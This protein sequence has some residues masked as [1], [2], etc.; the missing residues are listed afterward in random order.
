MTTWTARA[1]LLAAD[2]PEHGM[3]AAHLNAA[4]W[5]AGIMPEAT[6]GLIGAY[7]ALT[8]NRGGDALWVRT[9]PCPDAAALMLATAELEAG[10]AGL[11]KRAETIEGS[12]EEARETAIAD[13]R[14][15][16]ADANSDEPGIRASGAERM[17][18]ARQ[19]IADTEAAL[20]IIADAAARLTHARICLARVPGDYATVYAEPVAQVR[21]GLK[22]PFAGAY[23]NGEA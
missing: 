10:A 17:E 20:E 1:L 21:R 13:Y 22:L 4:A 2:L 14:I 6:R 12:C 15:A 11:L 7:A 9:G 8:G 18:I 16:E 19:V 3:N 5:S 23:L